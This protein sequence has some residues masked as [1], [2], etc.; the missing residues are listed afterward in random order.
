MRIKKYTVILLAALGILAVSQPAFA[1]KEEPSEKIEKVSL[2]IE[3]GIRSG[4]DIINVDIDTGKGYEVDSVTIANEPAP[5]EKWQKD[6]QPI[7][8]IVLAVED[9]DTVF[10]DIGKNDVSITGE[11]V[12]I[13]S[14]NTSNKDRKLKIKLKFRRIS[15]SSRSDS[16]QL[17]VA[18]LEWLSDTAEG[19]WTGGDDT[20]KFEVKLYKDDQIVRSA[21][22][23]EETLSFANNMTTPGTYFFRVRGMFDDTHKGNWKASSKVTINEEKA[24]A[25]RENYATAE[26]TGNAGGTMG[27]PSGTE[28]AVQ[29][30]ANL[31]SPGGQP[32]GW[33]EENGLWWYR[34]PDGSYTV[35]NWQFINDKWYFFDEAGWMK[36]GWILWNEK[37]YYCG[38]DGAMLVNT[39]TPDQ[40]TVGED[41]AR[42]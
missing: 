33:I 7:L 29:S 2:E 39:T 17:K 12:S 35:N 32:Y 38:E 40:Y 8:N 3:S 9:D 14:V 13:N 21:I 1:A 23:E 28:T 41:G 19:T 30:T 42:L 22:T 27:G 6:D 18:D 36:T 10:G 11:R 26:I 37:Y 15:S 34:N 5:G 24:N 4:S 31:A 16:M 25:I 20:E